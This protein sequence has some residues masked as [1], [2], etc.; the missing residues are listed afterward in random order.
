MREGSAVGDHVGRAVEAVDSLVERH[1]WTA[2]LLAVLAIVLGVKWALIGTLASPTPFWDQWDGEAANLYVPYLRGE[3]GW[4]QLLAAHNEHRIFATRLL[5]LALLEVAGRWNT[6]LQ[7]AV[8][9][10][11]HVTFIAALL[12]LLRRAGAELAPALAAAFAVLLFAVPY[13]VENILSGFQ[14]QFYLL[15]LVTLPALLLLT[16][17]RTLG[18]RWWLGLALIAGSTLIMASGLL[19]LPA[20]AALVLLQMATDAR[21]RRLRE[22]VGLLLLAG[23]TV[24]LLSITVTVPGH[25]TLKAHSAWEFVSAATKV[26]G[27]PIRL[28]LLA[29]VVLNAPL[30]AVAWRLWRERRGSGAPEWR[31]LALGLWL[32]VPLLSLA[33]GRAAGVFT[34]RYLDLMTPSVMINAV[35]LI[36]EMDRRRARAALSA[37]FA[38]GWASLVIAFLMLQAS[39]STAAEPLLDRVPTLA[40]TAN[41]QR[42]IATR[43]PAMLHQPRLY[44]PFPDPDRLA[45]ILRQPEVLGILPDLQPQPTTSRAAVQQRLA[46]GGGANLSVGLIMQ[47]TKLLGTLLV[48]AG[49]SLM[50]LLAARD[51]WARNTAGDHAPKR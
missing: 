27:W 21:P 7:M 35:A 26:L 42:F 22:G 13:G 18:L 5:D 28:P 36:S 34:S 8:N 29:P 16:E 51:R 9:A 25:A 47:V 15:L 10:V 33:Y 14:S 2:W 11:L 19:V 38:A 46:L 3:L 31:L 17:A 48:A 41:V 50:L 1:R 45:V 24:A 30:L 40:R 37:S 6:P 32:A 49:L 43:D 23:L 4:R 20:A 12:A 44:I 39:Y